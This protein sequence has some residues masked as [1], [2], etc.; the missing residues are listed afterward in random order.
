MSEDEDAAWASSDEEVLTEGPAGV[1]SPTGLAGS[2]DYY[3]GSDDSTRSADE[4]VGPAPP[5]PDASLEVPPPGCGRKPMS[6]HMR[7]GDGHNFTGRCL[8]CRPGATCP[9]AGCRRGPSR[10]VQEV[11]RYVSAIPSNELFAGTSVGQASTPAGANGC[12][13]HPE[14]S[15][16]G[17]VSSSTVRP[18]YPP[19]TLPCCVLTGYSSS[20]S[21][22]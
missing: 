17:E 5:R 12:S 15:P 14:L 9:A 13:G 16:V 7:W 8:Q 21:L 19:P 18:P 3:S 4:A 10:P 20:R 22:T 2:G 1:E 11:R 6:P